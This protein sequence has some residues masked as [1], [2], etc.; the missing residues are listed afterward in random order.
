MQIAVSAAA[1]PESEPSQETIKSTCPF[2]PGVVTTLAVSPAGRVVPVREG[3]ATAAPVTVAASIR[4]RFVP[5]VNGAPLTFTVRILPFK[6]R[7]PDTTNLPAAGEPP[8][9]AS[10]LAFEAE[11]D[12]SRLP[13]MVAA[14]VP[15]L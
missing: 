8:P 1:L 3:I 13:V 15:L 10:N 6:V 11:A 5:R 9:V 12:R 14:L 7:A 4:R 2:T